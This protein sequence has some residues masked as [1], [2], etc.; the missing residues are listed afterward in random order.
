MLQFYNEFKISS[1]KEKFFTVLSLI[2]SYL[3]PLIG[4]IIIWCE[5]RKQNSLLIKKASWTGIVVA[6]GLFFIDF[7]LF[8]IS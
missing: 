6:F 3:I 2:I 8:T 5:N 1:I 4:I 7:I